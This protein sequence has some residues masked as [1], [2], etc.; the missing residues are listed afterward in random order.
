MHQLVPAHMSN[1]SPMP[2]KSGLMPA[3]SRSLIDMFHDQRKKKPAEELPA[4]KTGNLVHNMCYVI[5]CVVYK[6]CIYLR[7]SKIS[8]IFYLTFFAVWMAFDWL[9]KCHKKLEKLESPTTSTE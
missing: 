4:N 5:M 2:L 7:V 8:G 1:F 6:G 3:G 9:V